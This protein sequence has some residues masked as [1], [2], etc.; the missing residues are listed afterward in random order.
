MRFL[1]KYTTPERK[2]VFKKECLSL[3]RSE[4]SLIICLVSSVVPSLCSMMVVFNSHLGSRLQSKG[5]YVSHWFTWEVKI[6]YLEKGIFNLST[7]IITFFYYLQVLYIITFYVL[8]KTQGKRKLPWRKLY[9][10]A[11]HF[12]TF[13][14][15]LL[16]LSSEKL[17]SQRFFYS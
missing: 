11:Y 15:R 6:L 17:T 1:Y 12:S 9:G 3:F 14:M 13:G 2:Q 5:H 16:C 8:F 7:P 10:K 4:T